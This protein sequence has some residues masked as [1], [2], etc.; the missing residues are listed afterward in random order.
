MISISDLPTLN[1]VLNSLSAILLICGFTMIRRGRVSAHKAFMISAFV[2]SI[3][4]LISYLIYHYHTGSKF[5]MGVGTI[6]IIY[7]A[8]L[9]THTILAAFVP[10]LASITLYF[11]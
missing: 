2:T 4:F 3:L 11:A 10:F 5:F 6:R 1:A 7:F 8:I 9:I